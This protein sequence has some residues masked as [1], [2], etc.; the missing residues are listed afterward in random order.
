MPAIRFPVDDLDPF[1]RLA[2]RGVGGFCFFGGDAGLRDVVDR[3]QAAAPHRLLFA[4]DFEDGAGQQIAGLAKH[5]PAM[6]FDPDGA[7]AAGVR[8]AIE[9]RALGITMT[10]APVCDVLSEP[11]NPIIQQR[12]YRD[13]AA[14]APRFVRGAR[15]FGLRTC[16]KHFPGHGATKQDS[17]DALPRV[18]AD[19]A[20]WRE[21]DLVPFQRCIDA[22]VDAIMS[23][24]LAAPALTGSNTLPTTL[25]H[26][27]ITDLLRGDMGFSGLV[28]TDALCM[29]GV[30]QGRT[31]AEAAQ[32]ALEAGCDALLCPDDVEGVLR[33]A[34][35][36]EAGA[37]LA[38]IAE[39]ADPLP[40]PME[41]A[42][43]QSIE[44]IGEVAIGKGSH[45]AR[46]FDLDG[47]GREEEVADL[48]GGFAA[49]IAV[50]LRR[51]RAWGG[52]LRLTDEIRAAG[53][54][55]PLLVLLGP[56]ALLEDLK[57]A[58]ALVA[59]GHDPFTLAEVVRRIVGG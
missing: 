1:L 54:E 6:A 10:F 43:A 46:V 25:S 32:L 4:A 56:R 2:E 58:A 9:S 21:R 24:H 42:A 29:D 37:A 48:F 44:E 14:C 55:A 34:E 3:L 27:V 15:A 59:P 17:H 36:M 49:P 12:A 47:L 57:P 40:G 16:A 20:T 23:A 41:R 52:A 39:A 53:R 35:G 33:A 8:T 18:D 13:P 11:T 22:G 45:R 19:E 26:R 28:L 30:L 51:D 5:P 38:R 50:V 7:E 31:E